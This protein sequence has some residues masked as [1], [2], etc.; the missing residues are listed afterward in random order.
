MSGWES[1]VRKRGPMVFQTAWRTLRDD[2]QESEDVTQE[3]LLVSV[4]WAGCN[5][6]QWLA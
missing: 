6:G 3:V 2:V 5:K 4:W 1:L